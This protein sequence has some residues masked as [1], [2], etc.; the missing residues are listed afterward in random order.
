MEKSTDCIVYPLRSSYSS[1]NNSQG[2]D[3]W[4]PCQMKWFYC[5]WCVSYCCKQYMAI[6]LQ[7]TLHGKSNPKWRPKKNKRHPS[8][9]AVKSPENWRR[10]LMWKETW[11]I[12]Q[13]KRQWLPSLGLSWG[14]A[15]TEKACLNCAWNWPEM[16]CSW[17][18]E[19][20]INDRIYTQ[21][22]EKIGY[23]GS[24]MLWIYNKFL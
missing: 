20:S 4:V 3:T 9:S 14:H 8:K 2:L 11:R 19:F 18:Y 1:N 16:A 13:W 12:E 24:R 6:A 23:Q 17:W 5:Q 22:K 21:T 7:H 15:C 10:N